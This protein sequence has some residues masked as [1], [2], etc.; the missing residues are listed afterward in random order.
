MADLLVDLAVY[1]DAQTTWTQATDLFVGDLPPSPDAVTV[2][3]EY[4]GG[5]P[6]ETMGADSSPAIVNPRVQVVTRAATYPDARARALLAYQKLVLI[7][8]ETVNSTYYAR[9]VPVQEPFFLARDESERV[10]FAFNADV[11][12]AAE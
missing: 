10:L 3:Y 7:A 5:E 11:L 2:L 12:R 1:L 9:V 6:R 4:A 8:N